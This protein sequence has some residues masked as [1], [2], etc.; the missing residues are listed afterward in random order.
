MLAYYVHPHPAQGGALRRDLGSGAISWYD[1][2][3][4]NLLHL[5]APASCSE[6]GFT[7]T[8]VHLLIKHSC[9]VT[10]QGGTCEDYPACGHEQGDCNGLLYG[11]DE[12]IKAQVMQDIATGHGQCD[13]ADGLYLCEDMG[14]DDEDEGDD[15]CDGTGWTGNPA[16]KCYDHYE[17]NE[18]MTEL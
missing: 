4:T 2:S 12:A 14:L 10:A 13:H 17:P 15:C 9:Q 7:T 6:C 18:F 5:T 11:S 3:M 8:D 1:G 16:R